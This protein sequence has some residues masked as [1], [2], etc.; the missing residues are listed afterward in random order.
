MTKTNLASNKYF[1]A[2]ESFANNSL[3]LIT[4]IFCGSKFTAVGDNIAASNILSI[5]SSLT[6]ISLNFL[7][8]E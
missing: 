1:V 7:S 6:S 2:V 8:L 4:Y 5:K 3:F